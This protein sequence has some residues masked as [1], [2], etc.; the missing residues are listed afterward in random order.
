MKIIL[1]NAFSLNMLNSSMNISFKEIS[2]EEA[3]KILSENSFES[4]VGHAV[5][6]DLFSNLLNQEV[7]ANR[8]NVVFDSNTKMLIGQYSGPRIEEVAKTL[9]DGAKIKFFFVECVGI[10]K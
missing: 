1:S 3:K 6:A 9:P 4:A 2:L 5:T 7:K 8:V 10:D